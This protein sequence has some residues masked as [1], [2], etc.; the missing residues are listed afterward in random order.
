MVLFLWVCPLISSNVYMCI[1]IYSVYCSVLWA[2][3]ETGWVAGAYLRLWACVE[4]RFSPLSPLLFVLSW[5]F[6]SILSCFTCHLPHEDRMKAFLSFLYFFL[7]QR[8]LLWAHNKSRFW[9]Q[10]FPPLLPVSVSAITHTEKEKA[11]FEW[12]SKLG[13]L[14][15]KQAFCHRAWN[16]SA[17]NF[18]GKR[19]YTGIQ[20]GEES[21]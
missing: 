3:H 12:E 2:S 6:F 8:N 11:G 4:V 13:T 17:W 19:P 10:C 1:Y 20:S 15:G 16:A 7:F 14:R 18:L 21:H 5:L 9:W